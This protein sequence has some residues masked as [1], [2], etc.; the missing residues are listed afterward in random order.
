MITRDLKKEEDRKEKS[1][2]WDERFVSG[3]NLF[4]EELEDSILSLSSDDV[5][6]VSGG[7]A[8]VT[9][10][11]IIETARA[12]EDPGPKYILLGRSKLNADQASLVNSSNEVLDQEK[13]ALRER[14]IEEK[15]EKVSL[16]EWNHQWSKWLRGLE[17]HQT[18]ESIRLTGNEAIYLSVDAVSYTH[19]TLPTICSV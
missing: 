5:W 12:S 11:C 1:T 14:M 10:A 3:T 2:L 17:I 13:N 9:A 8:G 6:V 16:K 4:E 18:L 15:G 7:G 19:L